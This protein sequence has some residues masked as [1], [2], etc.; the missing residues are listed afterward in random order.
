MRRHSYSVYYTSVHGALLLNVT[1][2][3]FTYLL[4]YLLMLMCGGQVCVAMKTRVADALE[5]RALVALG[6]KTIVGVGFPI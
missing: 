3:K 4:T 1:I 6:V 5:Q 2:C